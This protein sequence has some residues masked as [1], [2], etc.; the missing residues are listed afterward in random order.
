MIKLRTL[1]NILAVMGCISVV[2]NLVF[3][4]FLDVSKH[5]TIV[6]YGVAI[7]AI[8]FFAVKIMGEIID[9]FYPL[10]TERD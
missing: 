3:S 10:N 1:I 6:D 2:T 5:L 7:L 4:F 9:V 8:W